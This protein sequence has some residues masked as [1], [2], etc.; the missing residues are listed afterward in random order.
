MLFDTHSLELTM[1]DTPTR[2]W[3]QPKP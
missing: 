1:A 3:D 2:V